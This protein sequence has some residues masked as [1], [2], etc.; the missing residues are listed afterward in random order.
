MM[1]FT[2]A[3]MFLY[4][5]Q[6]H[7]PVFF[8]FPLLFAWAMFRYIHKFH[9]LKTVSHVLTHYMCVSAHTLFIIC[10]HLVLKDI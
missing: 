4:H 1:V 8:K 7:L 6:I 9:I 10:K 5:L 2:N 3:H